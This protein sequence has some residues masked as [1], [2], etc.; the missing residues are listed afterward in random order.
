MGQGVFLDLLLRGVLVHLPPHR[1]GRLS[2]P[3]LA[4]DG[5]GGALQ[6]VSGSRDP[7][8]LQQDLGRLLRVVQEEEM[9]EAELVPQL[10]VLRVLLGAPLQDRDGL[11]R[12]SGAHRR[13]LGQEDRAI[14]VGDLQPGIQRGGDVD[15]GIEQGDVLVFCEDAPAAEVLHGAHPVEVRGQVLEAGEEPLDVFPG[16]EVEDLVLRPERAEALIHLPLGEGYPRRDQRE[17][18]P[19]QPKH[20]HV[21][22]RRRNSASPIPRVTPV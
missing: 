13:G 14:A 8:G 7:A 1:P 4:E 11:A 21:S 10:P 22:S 2:L 6:P 19:P 15:E 20:L 3:A 9:E 12:A 18:D 5:R 17:E 16:P